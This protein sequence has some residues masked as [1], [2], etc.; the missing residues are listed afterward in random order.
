MQ[1]LAYIR[2]KSV[3]VGYSLPETLLKRIKLTRCRIYL[4]GENL[5]TFTK[6]KSRY[7]DPEQLTTDPNLIKTDVNGRVYPFSKT[8]SA[9]LDISF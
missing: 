9:G 4:S 2:L 5:L 8:F 3:I 6:L 1:D 7:L